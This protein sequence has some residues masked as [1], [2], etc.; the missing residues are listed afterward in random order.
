[1]EGFHKQSV[2]LL[3]QGPN[4][5][6]WSIKISLPFSFYVDSLEYLTSYK[7]HLDHNYVTAG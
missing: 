7:C 1:M 4:S 6:N 5:R 3:K 2:N